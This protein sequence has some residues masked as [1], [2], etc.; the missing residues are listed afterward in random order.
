MLL[1]GVTPQK[2]IATFAAAE[3]TELIISQVGIDD[4]HSAADGVIFQ[5]TCPPGTIK[6]SYK[7][8]HDYDGVEESGEIFLVDNISYKYGNQKFYENGIYEAIALQSDESTLEADFEIKTIDY[9]PPKHDT[10]TGT[11]K[12]RWEFEGPYLSWYTAYIED[13]FA[14]QKQDVSSGLKNIIVFRDRQN[15]LSLEEIMPED[16]DDINAYRNIEPQTIESLEVDI[17]KKLDNISGSNL[18]YDTY[19]DFDIDQEGG[20]YYLYA[21][22]NVGNVLLQRMFNMYDNTRYEFTTAD[23]TLIDYTE[24]INLAAT[25]LAELNSEYANHILDALST[26]LSRIRFSFYQGDEDEIMAAGRAFDIAQAA[27]TNAKRVY[28]I[29]LI[30]AGVFPNYEKISALNFDDSTVS[31][32]KGETA[33]ITLTFSEYRQD[34]YDFAFIQSAMGINKANRLFKID[35]ILSVDGKPVELIA[36]IKLRFAIP[37]TFNDIGVASV[38]DNKITVNE[39]ERGAEWLMLVLSYENQYFYVIIN[40]ENVEPRNETLIY[41]LIGVACLV[42]LIGATIV[43]VLLKKQRNLKKQLNNTIPNAD[44]NANQPTVKKQATNTVLAPTKKVHH[45]KSKKRKR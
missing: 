17:I 36:P 43:L 18:V 38:V 3:E 13:R 15:G 37:T 6:L 20:T 29:E 33:K 10:S 39:V 16:S 22:D 27:Y 31:I 24:T 7:F 1:I 32:L 19:I 25:R 11:S 23:G 45:N 12:D 42:F 9:M 21:R 28:E 8:V 5:F 30:G 44:E 34:Y 2:T 26:A 41:I 4:H 40:D 14:A 35:S